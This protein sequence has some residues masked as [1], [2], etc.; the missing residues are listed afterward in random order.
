[1][2]RTQARSIFGLFTP[3]SKKPEAPPPKAPVLAPDNLFHKLSESPIPALRARGER[4][5]TLAPCPVSMA[6]YGERRP[7]HF[8]CPDCGWPTHCSEEMWAQDTEHARYVPRL[9]EANEDEH[10]LRSG[11]VMT[12]FAL[13]R[14]QPHEEVVNFSGWDQ[15]FY[16]RNFPSINTERSKRH[17]SKLLTFPMTIAS[18]LHENSPYTRRSTRLTHEGLRSVTPLRQTLQPELGARPSLD[19]VRIF[20]VG[21]RAEATLPPDVWNQL[22]YI[23]PKVRVEIYLIGPEVAI[24]GKTEPSPWNLSMYQNRDTYFACPSRSI[25][26]S[27]GVGLTAL[28]TT[29]EKIHTFFEPFDPYTDVF[30]AFSPGFGFPSL[31]AVEEQARL[32]DELRADEKRMKE[33]RDTFYAKHAPIPGAESDTHYTPTV[34][35]ANPAGGDTPADEPSPEVVAMRP[36]SDKFTSL[37]TAPVVQAQREWAQALGQILSTRCPLFISGFSPADVE[38]DVL[39]FESVEGVSGEFDWLLTPGENA[40]ASQQWAIADFDTRIA[41]KANWGIWGVRGKRYDILGPQWDTT[42]S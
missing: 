21:A 37:Q 5:R 41:V 18:A 4:I 17:V 10:D 27:A 1:M 28:Q 9:R 20:V 30:F 23:F 39:A 35:A 36:P 14:D 8:E 42:N 33:A 13:P 16:T 15:L 2:P 22:A 12:E 3:K 24:P 34:V 11:R 31:I 25:A 19:P 38:R 6:K 26:V 40:F 29:Y 32:R 7:V